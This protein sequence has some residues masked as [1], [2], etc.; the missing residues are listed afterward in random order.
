LALL[1]FTDK[2]IYCEKGD[3]FIDPWRGVDYAVITH[4]HADHARGGSHHYLAHHYSVPLLKLRLSSSIAVRGV[5][6]GESVI[7]NGVKISLHPAGHIIG[8]AQVRIE[9]D[10]EVW[11][12]S[13]DY[14]T[15]D[16]GL[17]TRFEPVKCNY[18]ITES[19][20]ALPVYHFPEARTCWDDLW[21]WHQDNIRDGFHSFVIGYSLGKAQRIVLE[22]NKRNVIPAVHSAIHQIHKAL[23]EVSPGFET[24]LLKAEDKNSGQQHQF[25]IVPPGASDAKMFKSF[26]PYRTAMISG[27]MHLRGARRWRNVDQ[28]FA[29][30]D[31]ADWKGLND[32]VE[33]TGAE[34]IIVTHGYKSIFSRWLREE[35]KL[36][37]F[38]VETLFEGDE[39]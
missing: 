34:N 15:C 33:A 21:Q 1:S 24:T 16:D 29:I 36:N 14:K 18:F 17:S 8:S 23:E 6:Y 13:G 31:H 37:A 10:G 39:K 35:K 7:R 22:M 38:E 19:T 26:E 28:G 9:A 30:S 4:A 27:W 20:F 32:A 5:E 11:V 12:V 25:L 3:F 2:G